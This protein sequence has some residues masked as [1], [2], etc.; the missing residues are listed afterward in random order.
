MANAER[1]EQLNALVQKAGNDRKAAE[2]INNQKGASPTH[3]AIFK[4]RKGA[5]TDYIVQC[6][7]D[8]LKS[9]LDKA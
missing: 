9:A 6:Y 2:L 7:I 4:A 8:D 5:A 3:S 1:T